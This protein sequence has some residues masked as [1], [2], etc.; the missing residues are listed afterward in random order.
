MPCLTCAKDIKD[1]LLHPQ[2]LVFPLTRNQFD[3]SFILPHSHLHRDLD[4]PP[5]TT[6][7]NE[8]FVPVTVLFSGYAFIVALCKAPA[9]RATMPKGEVTRLNGLAGREQIEFSLH[10]ETIALFY[11]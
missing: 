9:R 1:S 7:Q 8:N 11:F 2:D 5:R 3:I 4:S 6:S 10:T